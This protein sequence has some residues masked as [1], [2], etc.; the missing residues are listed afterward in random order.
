MKYDL[1]IHSKYS[2]DGFLEPKSI[3]KKAC[4]VGLNGLAITDHNT[5][6]GGLKTRK[7]QRD[8]IQVIVGSEILTDRGEVIGLFLDDEIKSNIFPEVV[9]EIKDQNGV[10]ILPHPFDEIRRNGIMPK[11]EDVHLVDCVEVYNSRCLM[12]KYNIKAQDFAQTNKMKISA[13]SDAHFAGEIGKAGIK[14]NLVVNH[15]EELRELLLKGS[16]T[17]FGEKSN[18]INL[19][20]TKVLKIWRKTGFG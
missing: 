2:K 7:Y 4:K 10:V 1:H 16:I 11:K 19:G 8:N 3:I 20:L 5:I 12:E 6:K 17:F 15:P 14:T 13:G 9:Q 18:I